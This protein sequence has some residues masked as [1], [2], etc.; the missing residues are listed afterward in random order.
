MTGI[1]VTSGTEE[2]ASKGGTEIDDLSTEALTG[3]FFPKEVGES[4]SAATEDLSIVSDSSA[5]TAEGEQPG[6]QGKRPPLVS[7]VIDAE[8][9][10]RITIMYD[11]S[12]VTGGGD[13]ATFV[14]LIDA[15]EANDVVDLTVMTS[16][17][18]LN[19]GG[20]S[21]LDT[22]NLL[23]AIN[24][25]KAHVVTR[26]G[27]LSS[28]SDIAV[29]LSGD[30]R[31][32]SPM[33]WVVVR[34][35]STGFAGSVTDMGDRD[36]ANKAQIKQFT[37]FIVKTGFLTDAEIKRIIDDQDV[38]GFSYDELDARIKALKA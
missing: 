15:A 28:L 13:M 23:S 22:I 27:C 14:G 29:W 35:P 12:R 32:M 4:V 30:E 16:L 8:G 9:H 6:A 38:V 2:L 17:A 26:A 31:H 33:G 19:D 5:V 11:S 20:P 24:R 21:L 37:D 10:A 34:Q 18:H 25:C 7:K 1:Q 36:E 3:F